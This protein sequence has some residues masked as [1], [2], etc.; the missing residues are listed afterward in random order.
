MSLSVVYHLKLLLGLHLKTRCNRW[1][2]LI[3]SM[4]GWQNASNVAISKIGNLKKK[5]GWPISSVG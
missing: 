5:K 3:E 2:G 1:V 4:Y